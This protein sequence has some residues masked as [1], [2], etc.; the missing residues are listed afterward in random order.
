MYYFF[1]STNSPGKKR[2]PKPIL[3]ETLKRTQITI[4]TLTRRKLMVLGG[5]N[6][7]SAGIRKAADMA[8]ERYQNEPEKENPR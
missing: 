2:G 8:Y 3:G 4:D 6:N 1:M 7:L 5:G